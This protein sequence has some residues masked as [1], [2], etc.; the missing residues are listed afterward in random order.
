[1][2]TKKTKRSAGFGVG[3]LEDEDDD[4]F[5]GNKLWNYVYA[6]YMKRGMKKGKK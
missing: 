1:M 3:V 6:I 5:A 4:V 2:D